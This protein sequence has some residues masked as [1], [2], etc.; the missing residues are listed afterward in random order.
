MPQKTK[1]KAKERLDKQFSTELS[2]HGEELYTIGANAAQFDEREAVTNILKKHISTLTG[3]ELD[4][5]DAQE[6]YDL[7]KEVEKPAFQVLKTEDYRAM[8]KWRRRSYR[9]TAKAYL[10]QQAD[11]IRQKAAFKNIHR[12]VF[13]LNDEETKDEYQMD[14]PAEPVEM[15]KALEN[16][17]NT[18][19]DSVNYS[20]SQ[21]LIGSSTWAKMGIKSYCDNGGTATAFNTYYRKD[22]AENIL[23]EKQTQE[24]K[25]MEAVF[26][27]ASLKVPMVVRR[28]VGSTDVLKHMLGVNDSS[29]GTMNDEKIKNHI[30]EKLDKKQDIIITEKGFCST[31]E[32]SKAGYKAG[33]TGHGDDGIEFVILLPKKT[34]ALSVKHISSHASEREVLLAPGTKFR[35]IKAFFNDGEDKVSEGEKPQ[36]YM[37]EKGTWKIYLE[38]LPANDDEGQLKADKAKNK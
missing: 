12:T 32:T 38:A 8:G 11:V 5:D 26:K 2:I 9:K 33:L 30:K 29:A 20:Q 6:I 10:K 16:G 37:G 36:A 28:G 17:A 27:K 19:F 21:R 22:K 13:K 18:Q 23:N 1:D 4:S 25:A 31:A 7:T 34:R 35:M 24:V 15:D 14:I 3:A